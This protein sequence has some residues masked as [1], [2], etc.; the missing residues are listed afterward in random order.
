MNLRPQSQQYDPE[1]EHSLEANI[2]DS[3]YILS[4]ALALVSISISGPLS[5]RLTITFKILD[6]AETSL[7]VSHGC[8]HIMLLSML[9]DTE[10]LKVNIPTRA[11][12]RFD[13]SWNEDRRFH[14]QLLHAFL[15]HRKFYGDGSGHFDGTAE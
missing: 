12:L 8:I 6:H 10:S 13:G 3:H 14:A 5:Q 4:S 15:H 9:I 7:S 1:Q 11:E 2:S